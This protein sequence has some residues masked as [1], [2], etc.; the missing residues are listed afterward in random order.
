VDAGSVSIPKGSRASPSTTPSSRSPTPA[1]ETTYWKGQNTSTAPDLPHGPDRRYE[2][3]QVSRLARV[4]LILPTFA[5][6]GICGHLCP[7]HSLQPALVSVG[8]RSEISLFW[9]R[10]RTVGRGRL[11]RVRSE[12][13]T[14]GRWVKSNPA[15][16]DSYV[17][18]LQT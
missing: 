17:H 18:S 3:A 1:S 4:E 5:G 7:H 14:R 10:C 2:P 8:R 12:S 16:I 11:R 9:Q 13:V 6:P 15:T